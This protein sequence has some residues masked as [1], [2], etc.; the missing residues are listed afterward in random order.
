MAGRENE[1]KGER[2]KGK[3]ERERKGGVERRKTGGKKKNWGRGAKAFIESRKRQRHWKIG[4]KR[5][6]QRRWRKRS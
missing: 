1:R 2:G 5:N 3:K 4:R 6:Q